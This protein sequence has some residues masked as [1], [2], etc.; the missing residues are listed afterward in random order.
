MQIH[1]YA[2]DYYRVVPHS[3]STVIW[4]S[5]STTMRIVLGAEDRRGIR[6][7]HERSPACSPQHRPERS[8]I[9]PDSPGYE[10]NFAEGFEPERIEAYRISAPLPRSWS[11][12]CNQTIR[13]TC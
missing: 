8:T 7:A 9:N 6:P 13:C 5:D 3:L 12:D 2:R 10:S 11:Y 1:V 4:S